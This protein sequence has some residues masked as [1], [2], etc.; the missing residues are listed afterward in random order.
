M[1]LS[2]TQVVDGGLK[3][4]AILPN[5][6]RT[7]AWP[8]TAWKQS[9]AMRETHEEVFFNA[10]HQYTCWIGL[11]QPNALADQWIGRA[12]Y[13]PNGEACKAKTADN[14]VHRFGGLV[15]DPTRCPAAFKPETLRTAIETWQTK[16]LI[17]GRL[18]INFTRVPH[19]N[20]VGHATGW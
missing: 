17:G 20:P 4:L 15:V 11:R 16:F 5:P 10:A 9:V 18:P 6:E 14:P 19:A 1:N 2:R 8:P 12:R 3:E 7:T 13:Q